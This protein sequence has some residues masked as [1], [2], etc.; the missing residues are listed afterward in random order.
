[1]EMLSSVKATFAKTCNCGKEFN[2]RSTFYKHIKK[3]TGK[4]DNP[5]EPRDFCNYIC[6]EDNCKF[7]SKVS[8]DLIDHLRSVHSKEVP[9]HSHSFQTY[10][11][12]K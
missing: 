3:C 5:E 10:A 4:N 9:I 11:G 12:K 1:M 7:K 8:T 2:V 6:K